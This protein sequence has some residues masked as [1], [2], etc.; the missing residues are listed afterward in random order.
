MENSS[1]KVSDLSYSVNEKKILDNVSVEIKKGHL[2]GIVGPNGAGKTTLLKVIC[3]I[4]NSSCGA[5]SVEG[6][7]ITSFKSKEL[8][9]KI[10]YL[11]Q[12]NNFNF[13][14]KVSD[15]VLM[16]R[17]P[18]LS[19]LQNEGVEDFKIAIKALE[20]VD[21]QE[22]LDRNILTLSGGEQQR[23]SLARVIAQETDFLF[24]DEPLSNMDINHQ[25]SI[26]NLLSSLSSNGK[27]L[28][29]VLH[30]LRLAHR[31]CTKLLVLDKGKVVS[32]GD[33]KKVL[34]EDIISSVFKV[35]SRV[36]DNSLEFIQ[37]G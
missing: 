37:P 22:F 2:L 27:G 23:V 21:M 13:P 35:K 36:S 18:Y 7:N 15:I 4:L 3:G 8:F 30:D 10:S 34:N 31:F 33:P 25:L 29:V 17:Y 9:K 12:N 28:S 14:F 26:M 19:R 11:S 20:M 16:G 5:I 6:K 32:F 24:L 1:V